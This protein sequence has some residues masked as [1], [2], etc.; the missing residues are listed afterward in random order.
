[1][2]SLRDPDFRAV[3]TAASVFG[4]SFRLR[5]NDEQKTATAILR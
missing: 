5:G 3:A 2:I 4:S 1:L